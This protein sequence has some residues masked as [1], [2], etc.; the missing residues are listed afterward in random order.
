MPIKILSVDDEAPIEL[1]LKQFVPQLDIEK[2][3]ELADAARGVA[4]PNKLKETNSEE[5]MLADE[6]EGGEE[7]M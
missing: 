3:D 7:L 1:L 5:N 2:L 4:T 6:A